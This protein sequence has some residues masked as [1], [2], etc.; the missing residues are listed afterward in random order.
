MLEWISLK[1]LLSIY[2]AEYFNSSIHL[3]IHQILRYARVMIGSVMIMLKKLLYQW[4]VKVK[5]GALFNEN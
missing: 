2:F 1:A 5:V 4:K 3:L